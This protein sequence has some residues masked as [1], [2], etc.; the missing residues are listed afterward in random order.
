MP[1]KITLQS[2]GITSLA[3]LNK[4]FLREWFFR[5]VGKKNSFCKRF[6]FG[7]FKEMDGGWSFKYLRHLAWTLKSN[8][9]S[10]VRG[11]FWPKAC[12]L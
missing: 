7:K 1:Q 11:E 10:L 9:V 8:M 4:N 2:V 5:F 12:I 3:T 6:V